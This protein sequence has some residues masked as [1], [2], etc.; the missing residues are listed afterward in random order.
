MIK[1]EKEK[2]FEKQFMENMKK[3]LEEHNLKTIED[4]EIHLDENPL[5]IG[6]FTK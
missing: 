4:V 5:N 2:Q 1:K 6:M 3:F